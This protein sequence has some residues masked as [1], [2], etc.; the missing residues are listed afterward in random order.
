MKKILVLLFVLFNF[1]YANSKMPVVNLGFLYQNIYVSQ[2]EAAI[3]FKAWINKLEQ[4]TDIKI[5][6]HFYEDEATILE[7]YLDKRTLDTVLINPVIFLKNRAILKRVS[8]K[9]YTFQINDEKYMKYYLIKNKKHKKDISAR[10]Q[11]L[12]VVFNAEDAAAKL[13][14]DKYTLE[15]YGKPYRRVVSK[16]INLTKQI[17]V[18]YEV[19]F[20]QNTLAVVSNELYNTAVELNPQLKKDLQI[21]SQSPRMFSI[22]FGMFHKDL[23]LDT[24]D[25]LT[26]IINEFNNTQYGKDILAIASLNKIVYISQEELT[27]F[28]E[29][30]K[31][32]LKTKN[33]YRRK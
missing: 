3:A 30:Y 13:W 33:K 12:D 32:Y 15:T 17:K 31:E 19:F 7:D 25:K 4:R 6:V 26:N 27:K 8:K 2:K 9:Y 18:I 11:K 16:E 23:P 1:V 28:E 20:N 24:M 10:L 29:F 22:I 21:I 14:F 5:N